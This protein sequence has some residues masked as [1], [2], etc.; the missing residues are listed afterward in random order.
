LVICALGVAGA[1]TAPST[2]APSVG[3]AT[4]KHQ[5]QKVTWRGY[6]KVT[7][8]MK[9]R[10]AAKKVH[11][12]LWK[13]CAKAGLIG[14][15]TSGSLLMLELDN[16]FTGKH[17]VRRIYTDDPRFRFPLG[18]HAKMTKKKVRAKLGKRMR[19]TE[20]GSMLYAVGPHGRVVWAYIDGK[21]AYEVG[22]TYN[23]REFKKHG[24]ADGC[25]GA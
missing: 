17:T 5:H 25:G 7:F 4:A 8:G 15:N 23:R 24:A 19:R 22:V 9:L 11:G 3:L 20:H 16:G 13:D 6:H 18:L 10:K 1:V 2:A 21:S 12:T 14:I